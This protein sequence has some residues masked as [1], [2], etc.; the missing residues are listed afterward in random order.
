MP[1][2]FEGP[3]FEKNRNK[4]L[5]NEVIL[6]DG[7]ISARKEYEYDADGRKVLER[8]SMG[9]TEKPDS[10]QETKFKY[11]EFSRLVTKATR[12]EEEQGGFDLVDETTFRYDDDNRLIE[13]R[14]RSTNVIGLN[15]I[16]DPLVR[17]FHYDD[18]NR[19][20]KE[21]ELRIDQFEFD[22]HISEESVY[23]Y[24][25]DGTYEKTST[26]PLGKS[27]TKYDAEGQ[28]VLYENYGRD[29]KLKYQTKY[30]YENGLPVKAEMVHPETGEVMNEKTYSYDERRNL[31]RTETKYRDGKTSVEERRLEYF[32]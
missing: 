14:E 30:S 9:P 21:V 7:E 8:S 32:G 5:K 16:H 28:K 3:E 25:Q 26:D 22:T 1:E 24:A 17:Y 20:I 15:D 19:L 6:Y 4:W 10:F 18:K 11:D 31:T 29:G 27:V 13:Q 12:Q 2:I 23:E